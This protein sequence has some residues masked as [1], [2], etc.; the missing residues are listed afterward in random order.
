MRKV[1]FAFLILSLF[2]V[3]CSQGNENGSGNKKESKTNFPERSIELIVPYPPGGGTDLIGRA[4][5]K[6]ISKYLPNNQTMTVINKPGGAGVV[7]VSDFLKAK[8]DGY[9][10]LMAPIS[11]F[12]NTPFQ[13]E[14]AFEYDS[15][16]PL[17]K[18]GT[19]RQFV[20]VQKDA[21]WENFEDWLEYVKNNPN[22]FTYGVTGTGGVPHLAME[23]LNDLQNVKTKNVAFEGAGPAKTALLGGHVE[24]IVAPINQ[25]DRADLRALFGFSEEKGALTQDIPLLKES[26]IDVG[27]DVIQA[28]FIP[29]GVPEEV[30]KILS[31]A[32]KKT[33]EDPE[34][35]EDFKKTELDLTYANA[36][37]LQKEMDAERDKL[38]GINEKLGLAK[39]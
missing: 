21:P 12:T 16:A 20:L 27:L 2:I 32:I 17:A 36:E 8:S 26:G 13:K 35:I 1:L 38:K 10:V 4:I 18:I 7:G 24:G 15:F 25:A 34:F 23:M 6:H 28:M 9:E 37:G 30:K 39:K 5:S 31:E 22:K 29:Q 3:G 33:V 14:V 19:A 11:L